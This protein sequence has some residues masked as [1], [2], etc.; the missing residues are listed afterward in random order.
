MRHPDEGMTTAFHLN[1]RR[2]L[3]TGAA[4][5]IGA[6]TARICA[7]LGAELILVDI[8]DSEPV[9]DAIRGDGGRAV[10]AMADVGSRSDVER[11]AQ[12]VGVI[13]ALVLN[14][15]LCPWDED[16]MAPEWDAS[17]ERVMSVNVL[18]PLHAIRA[19]LPGMIARRA[20]HIVMIGSLAGRMG[21]LIAGPHYV[22]S[23]GGVHALVKWLARQA[24]PYNVL[25]NGIAPA[26]VETPMMNDRPVDLDRIPLGRKGKPEEIAWPIAFL[27]SD[28][29]SY[30][31]GTVL[32]V[33]GGVYMS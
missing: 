30:I 31:C 32:D 23:K 21:G 17:F 15:A 10:S 1:G 16:W 7:S 8:K 33:N 9:A 11:L 18:G 4:A 28:A 13:D 27:C 26:S 22:A 6:A 29:S 3:I 2:V 25:V 14:A 12:E 24:A 20:G 5:G 19:F